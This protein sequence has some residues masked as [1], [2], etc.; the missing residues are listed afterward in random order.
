MNH[1]TLR[2]A[3]RMATALNHL[4]PWLAVAL[5]AVG[6]AAIR[7]EE[8]Q[9]AGG[10]AAPQTPRRDREPLLE[11]FSASRAA[12]F[13]D[14]TVHA[15]E[16]SCFACH[17]SYMYLL[18]RPAVPLSA[19]THRE[20]RL[21]LE[22][23]IEALPAV[24]PDPR[25]ASSMRVA[26]AVMTA[27]ALS[28]NDAATTATLHPRTRRALDRIW[29][30]QREDGGWKWP[31][32]GG[33]PSEVDEHFPVTL[34]AIGVGAAPEGYAGTPKAREGLNRIRIYLREHPPATMH[35]R[36]MLL[37][38]SIH[39]DGLSTD[40]D[41]R[42]TAADLLAL[43]RPD[44]GWAMA[45]LGDASWKRKDGTPQDLESSD[46]YGTGFAVHVLR[47]AAGIPAE[48]P[49]IRKAVGWL[50]TH[51]RASGCW[52]TRSPRGDDELSTFTG[53]VYAVLALSECAQIPKPAGSP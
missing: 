23:S 34:A 15:T 32:N 44:G 52:F 31:L 26:D 29:D 33:P 53:T 28:L 51:Q 4:K 2:G 50:K 5:I 37:L 38:A 22:R 16:K 48:D 36:A 25:N 35:Q 20:T 19:G 43:Q 21:A 24:E 40:G 46:G 17:G 11:Q 1:Q 41:R 14:A 7:A 3:V 45:G 12:E 49:R 47:T 9:A 30:F 39:I 8:K 18:A 27:A 6:S 13:L 10:P 42:K